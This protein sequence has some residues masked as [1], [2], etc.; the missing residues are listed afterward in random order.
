MS[1]NS[2]NKTKS[3]KLIIDIVKIIASLLVGIFGGSL[4]QNAYVQSQVANVNGDGNTININSVD[5]LVKNY[6]KISEENETLKDQ[7]KEYFENNKESKET[8]ENLQKQLGDTPS[9]ELNDLGLCIEGE[10]KN[11]NKSNSYAIINGADYYSEE[12]LN[13]LV[14]DSTSITIKDDT[15]FLGKVV[16]DKSSLFSQRIVDEGGA[17]VSENTTDAYG[18]THVN[19]IKIGCNNNI[20]FSLDEKYSLLKLKIAIDESSSNDK[21]CTITIFADGKEVKTTPQLNKISTKEIEYK[22]LQI[23][24]CTRL[25]IKCNGDWSINPLIYDAEV[26]N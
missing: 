24:N 25:E 9:I 20:V 22:D 12:F 18:N 19:A 13:S 15:M 26:Y 16:A 7:N 14:P 17:S 4:I 5:D 10:D 11:I 2:T 21:Q 3:K 23:N 6:N 8:I 1:E